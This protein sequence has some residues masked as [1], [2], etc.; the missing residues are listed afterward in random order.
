MFHRLPQESFAAAHGLSHHVLTW[1][2]P[3][4]KTLILLHGWMDLAFSFQPLAEHLGGRYRLV[5]FDFRGHGDS[6]R[7]PPSGYYHFPDY[8]RDLHGLLPQLAGPHPILVGHSMGGTVAS[9]FTG[10]FPDRVKKLVIVDGLGAPTSDLEDSPDRFLKWM[11]G[12][13][14]VLKRAPR[15][16]SSVPDAADR[17]QMMNPRLNRELAL[18]LAEK[19]TRAVPGGGG[20]TWKHDPLHTTRS[21]FPFVLSQF[22]SFMRNISCPTLVVH[23]EDSFMSRWSDFPHRVEALTHRQ[24]VTI[25]GCGHMVHQEQ[26]AL[27]AEAIVRFVE[28]GN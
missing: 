26:P 1:E 21:A 22:L 14:Q 3:K 9:L 12:C 5:A 11:E 27:L 16:F 17:L 13:D 20:I 24:E 8:V 10:T 23:P 18:F 15:T 4:E 7:V 28:E 6:G 25:P 2:G 19:G